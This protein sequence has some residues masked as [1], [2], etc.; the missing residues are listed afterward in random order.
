MDMAVQRTAREQWQSVFKSF[1]KRD[2]VA[3]ILVD[4]PPGDFWSVMSNCLV[5]QTH[6]FCGWVR[7]A[8]EIGRRVHG[9]F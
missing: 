5:V 1:I 4:I 2:F 6:Q 7:V 9:R 8:F 3:L